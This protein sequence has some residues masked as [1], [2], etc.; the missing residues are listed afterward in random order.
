MPD[1]PG[2][3]SSTEQMEDEEQP[4]RRLGEYK[5]VKDI[6]EGTFGKVKSKYDDTHSDTGD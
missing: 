2:L 3:L 6:A 1:S 4:P 5:V